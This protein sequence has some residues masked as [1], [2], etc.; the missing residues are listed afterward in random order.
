[1][2]ATSPDL[3]IVGAGISASHSLV[4]GQKLWVVGQIKHDLCGQLLSVYFF[5]DMMKV[6][7]SGALLELLSE[8]MM[9]S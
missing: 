4:S 9:L 2:L 3:F 6:A 1:M 7:S 5:S 8:H